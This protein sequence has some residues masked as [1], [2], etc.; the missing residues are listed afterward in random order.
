MLKSY[1]EVL[2]LALELNYEERSK[3]SHE[4]WWSLHP[5]AEDL[6]QEQID[7]AWAAEIERRVAEIDSG[8]VEMVSW[9][10]LEAKLREKLS[11]RAS[12]VSSS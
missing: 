7:A 3:L 12:D 4:L 2:E 9:E 6:P 1:D 10:E 11:A 5:T 8:S